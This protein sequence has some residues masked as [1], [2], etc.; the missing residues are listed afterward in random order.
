MK[1]NNSSSTWQ[2]VGKTKSGKEKVSEAS[3]NSSSKEDQ[4]AN[5]GRATTSSLAVFQL[6]R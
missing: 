5:T 4:S 3:A 6:L 2:V 1:E